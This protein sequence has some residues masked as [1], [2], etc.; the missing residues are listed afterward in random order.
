MPWWIQHDQSTSLSEACVQPV[1]LSN[2]NLHG[3]TKLCLC[4]IAIQYV[5]NMNLHAVPG[6][7]IPVHN[8]LAG[9]ILHPLCHLDTHVQQLCLHL[10]LDEMAKEYSSEQC[11]AA[12]ATP[13]P[14]GLLILTPFCGYYTC[15]FCTIC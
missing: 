2:S 12:Q 6:R 3:L 13:H 7:E 8:S 5:G 9:Q 1:H 15:K 11:H 10:F 4:H 14:M